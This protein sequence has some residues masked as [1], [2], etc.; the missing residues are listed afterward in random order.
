MAASDMY[1]CY[2]LLNVVGNIYSKC[3]LEAG[4]YTDAI[5]P[6]GKQQVVGLD[7]FLCMSILRTSKSW[8][9]NRHSPRCTSPVMVILDTMQS[10]L[11]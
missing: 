6:P 7:E 9:V 11:R 2:K 8:E 10:A 4:V 3:E 5:L 1:Y